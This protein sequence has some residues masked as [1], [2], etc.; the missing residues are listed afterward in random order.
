MSNVATKAQ[1]AWA[2]TGVGDHAAE[3]EINFAHLKGTPGHTAVFTLLDQALC[4]WHDQNDP[5]CAH[6]AIDSACRILHEIETKGK[7]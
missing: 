6:N 1:V 4:Y 2:L 3:L 7:S 5:A